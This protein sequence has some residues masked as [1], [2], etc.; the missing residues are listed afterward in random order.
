MKDLELREVFAPF[1][2]EN[3]DPC[4]KSETILEK[5][6]G[7]KDCPEGWCP[8]V[9]RDSLTPGD[10]AELDRCTM[11]REQQLGLC[12]S[13]VDAAKHND[14]LPCAQEQAFGQP[15][16]LEAA[17]G[18]NFLRQ[19]RG[20]K[21]ER[22]GQGPTAYELMEELMRRVVLRKFKGDFYYLENGVYHYLP[23]S[24]LKS[25]VFYVLRDALQANGHPRLL[26]NVAELLTSN[27]D[28][29]VP[30]TTDSPERLYFSNGVLE[31]PQNIL[32]PVGPHD[33][34]TSYIAVDYPTGEIPGCPVFEKFLRD[35]SGGDELIVRTIWEMTGYLLVPGNEAKA[36]F[37]LQG[38]GNSG[39]SVL[40]NLISGLFSPDAVSYLDIFRLGGRF[41]VSALKRVRVNISMDLANGRINRQ[42]ISVIK[43][44]TGGDGV[45]MEAKFR[46]VEFDQVSCKLLF[47][48]NH[49][50]ALAEQDEAFLARLVAIPFRYAVPEDRQD[51]NLLQKLESERPAIVLRALAAYRELAARNFRFLMGSEGAVCG[52]SKSHEDL[53]RFVDECCI[54]DSAAKT[55]TKDLHLAFYGFCER[56]GL[57]FIQDAAAFSQ[58]LNRLCSGRAVNK[59][60]R[61]KG[62]SVNGYLGLSLVKGGE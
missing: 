33:F 8:V 57:P 43:S 19:L 17:F 26:T 39:K 11:L 14:C 9:P 13:D 36:F 45:P 54:F 56:H 55:S 28:L 16:V 5:Y 41:D 50:L 35:V 6:V 48:S 47:G 60:M 38:V 12:G 58:R 2:A 18:Q 32:R 34:F 49:L 51:K 42:A 40:G 23:D 4:R 15:S 20:A 62:E 31:V 24:E 30:I 27:P 3:D 7:R 44:I 46:N 21:E 37:V 10:A 53:E 52:Y 59:R 25:Y 29:R 61:I 22:K 1:L